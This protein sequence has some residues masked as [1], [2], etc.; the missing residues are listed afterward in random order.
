MGA[1]RSWLFLVKPA[2]S[3]MVKPPTF[4]TGKIVL[5]SGT[6]RARHRKHRLPHEVTLLRDNT[7]PRCA[8]CK[9]PVIFELLQAAKDETDMFRFSTRIVSRSK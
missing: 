9:E 6:Y 4:R 2:A 8:K 1:K 5:E 7:F 3:K